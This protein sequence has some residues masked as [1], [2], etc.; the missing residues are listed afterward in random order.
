[1]SILPIEFPKLWSINCKIIVIYIKKLIS[2]FE[3]WFNRQYYS[4]VA[5]DVA[6]QVKDIVYR[7][8]NA[9]NGNA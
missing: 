6:T 7:K 9:F 5:K 8:I 3:S 4:I 1:M 2:L